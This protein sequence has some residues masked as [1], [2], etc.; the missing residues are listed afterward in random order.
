MRITKTIYIAKK[1]SSNTLDNRG[2]PISI[3]DTPKLY[4]FNVQPVSSNSD[5]QIY[6]ERSITMQK[7]VIPISFLNHFKEFD[8]AYLDGASPTG[9][10]INGDNA[11]YV[12]KPPRNGNKVITI[13]FEKRG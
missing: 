6:G 11:N 8:I 1:I 2:N 3:Y 12:L 9:E 13:Y 4:E 5:I 7:A 10:I